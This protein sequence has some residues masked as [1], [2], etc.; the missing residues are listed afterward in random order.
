MVNLGANDVCMLVMQPVHA[1]ACTPRTQ[2]GMAARTKLHILYTGLDDFPRASHPSEEERHVD[3]LTWLALASRCLAT[4][5]QAA[6]DPQ[7]RH[8]C[9]GQHPVHTVVC[10]APSSSS[11]GTKYHSLSAKLC[12]APHY[13]YQRRAIAGLA[14]TAKC[15]LFAG[16][17]HGWLTEGRHDHT[18]HRN[19]VGPCLALPAQDRFR[20]TRSRAPQPWSCEGAPSSKRHAV[21]TISPFPW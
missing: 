19:A 8:S 4:I 10:S 16:L 21:P 18:L 13:Q 1:Q 9:S 20:L 2:H 6:Q 12:A 17:Q 15:Q 11:R 7:V 3:L 5:A 14:S